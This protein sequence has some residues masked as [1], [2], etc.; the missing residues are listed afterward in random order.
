MNIGK[1]PPPS[2]RPALNEKSDEPRYAGAANALVQSAHAE[3]GALVDGA[4][5]DALGRE[6]S[7]NFL[8]QL[9]QMQQHFRSA[10][11]GLAA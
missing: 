2:R 6:N 11:A 9:L 10:R 8:K 5:L 7:K 3:I 4:Q 1:C